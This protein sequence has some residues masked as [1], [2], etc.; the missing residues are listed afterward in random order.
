MTFR[1]LSGRRRWAGVSALLVCLLLFAL[2]ASAFAVTWANQCPA[3]GMVYHT[4]PGSLYVDLFGS[5]VNKSTAFISLDNGPNKL[6]TVAAKS[7]TGHWELNE[8]LQPD[9]VTWKA[10]WVWVADNPALGSTKVAL[11]YYPPNFGDGWH[12][13]GI[14]LKDQSSPA[15]SYATSWQFEIE[16]PP[17]IG[18]PSPAKG[19]VITNAM[20][21]L[22]VP[23][24]DNTYVDYCEFWVNGV[25]LGGGMV[26]APSGT[27]MMPVGPLPN[28][29][30]TIFV[31]AFDG[32]GN[33]SDKTWTFT[34]NAP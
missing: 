33:E 10:T 1:Y 28:G 16:V 22:L 19:S 21:T 25:Y 27:A 17:V 26:S 11:S 18:T 7:A 9:G 31:Q 8:A 12:R 5:T 24:A 14:S 34:V 20:P 15:N 23:V 2:P 6:L 30:N 29:L 13:A 4:Q 32:N 3:P